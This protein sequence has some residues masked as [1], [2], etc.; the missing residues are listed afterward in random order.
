MT[1]CDSHGLQHAL[2]L[3]TDFVMYTSVFN[4][5]LYISFNYYIRS[6]SGYTRGKK[7]LRQVFFLLNMSLEG[8]WLTLVLIGRNVSA[9]SKQDQIDA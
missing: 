7:P 9:F 3:I 5:V 1:L 8:P 6:D 2:G 4:S